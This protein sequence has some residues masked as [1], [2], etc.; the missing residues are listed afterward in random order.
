MEQ[1]PEELP[2][3]RVVRLIIKT[4][5]TAEIQVRGKFSCKTR[6]FELT[7]NTPTCLGTSPGVQQRD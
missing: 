5:G 2:Q 7:S 4:Q 1:V 6:S 3:V